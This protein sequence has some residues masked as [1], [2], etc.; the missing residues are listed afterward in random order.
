MKNSDRVNITP[1][2]EHI[3]GTGQIK[4]PEDLK[5][6]IKTL[7]EDPDKVI[8]NAK[9]MAKISEDIAKAKSS[10]NSKGNVK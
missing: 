7:R 8:F 10:S 9:D 2:L 4:T 5:L 1:M 6:L 3:F